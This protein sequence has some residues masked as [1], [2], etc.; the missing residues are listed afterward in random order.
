MQKQKN[1]TDQLDFFIK[2]NNQIFNKNLKN[3][4][5]NFFIV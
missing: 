4:A 5:F 1:P 2:T 3:Y